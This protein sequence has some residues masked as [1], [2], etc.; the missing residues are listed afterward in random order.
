MSEE[1]KQYLERLII[2]LEAIENHLS[3][4]LTNIRGY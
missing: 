3:E 1:D 2:L 4:I